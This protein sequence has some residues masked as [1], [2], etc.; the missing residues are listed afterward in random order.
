MVDLPLVCVMVGSA[1]HV[2]VP[3]MPSGQRGQQAGGGI[4]WM[5]HMGLGTSWRGLCC[6]CAS[7][8]VCTGSGCR[9][10]PPCFGPRRTGT[11]APFCVSGA[12]VVVCLVGTCFVSALV[13]GPP[14]CRASA[15]VPCAIPSWQHCNTC[16]V[17]EGGAHRTRP[18]HCPDLPASGGRVVGVLCCLAM[19]RPPP[20]SRLMWLRVQL[21]AA[22]PVGLWRQHSLFPIHARIFMR[23]GRDGGGAPACLLIAV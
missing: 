23:R 4:S 12:R 11:C 13:A 20:T 5:L 1:F 8:C 6:A 10:S 19:Y 7:Q 15:H 18:E 22:V 9:S 2:L 16:S 21:E 14:P 17:V 3:R